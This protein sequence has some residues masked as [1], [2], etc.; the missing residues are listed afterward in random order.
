VILANVLTPLENVMKSILDFFHS[1]VGLP[2]AWSIVALTLL[3]RIAIVPLM[4]K[5][6]HS[7]QAIQK[8]GPQIK[9]IQKKYKGDRQKM[10]EEVMAFYKENHINPAASCLPMLIQLPVFFALYL[11]LKHYSHHIQGSWLHVVPNIADK[12]TTHWSGYV[13]VAIYIGSQVAST[14]FMGAQ[15]DKM[16]R[17]IFLLLPLIMITVVLRFPIGLLMYWM[18]T[19]LW[20]VGQGLVT[21]RL[22]PRTPAP[23]MP[24]FG[25]R[26]TPAPAA[27]KVTK[28]V[29][30]PATPAAPKPKPATSGPQ[31]PRRVRR[32]KGG[33]RR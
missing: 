8:H 18:T 26:Q 3:V 28:A 24:S 5:Q 14:F 19:N 22:V 27:A 1:S 23:A 25:R 15:M 4:V 7:M 11:T 16:Q 20:T 31:Q 9:E 13:L 33:S 17:N 2:W 12:P 21:R 32:K 30:A 6:I 10:N 29:T